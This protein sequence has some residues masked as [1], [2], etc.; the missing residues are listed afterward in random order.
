MNWWIEYCLLQIS[1]IVR[2]IQIWI[3][4]SEFE[5]VNLNMYMNLNSSSLA[6][7][8]MYTNKSWS[9]IKLSNILMKYFQSRNTSCLWIQKMTLNRYY[10]AAN[11]RCWLRACSHPLPHDSF[12]LNRWLPS[13]QHDS[14]IVMQICSL[15]YANGKPPTSVNQIHAAIV[16]LL[17][18]L[19]L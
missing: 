13:S 7:F 10:G 17:C 5:W 19:D 1:I 6:K 11:S 4:M 9:P 14:S 16:T 18:K 8:G 2:M 12:R 3:W 15:W